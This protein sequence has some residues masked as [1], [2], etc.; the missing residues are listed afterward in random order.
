[1]IRNY[2]PNELLDVFD[3][4]YFFQNLRKEKEQKKIPCVRY[5]LRY[6]S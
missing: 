6:V 3:K 5:T 2:T 4:F 1:L